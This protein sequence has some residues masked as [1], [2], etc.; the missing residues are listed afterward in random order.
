MR[1]GYRP[2]IRFGDLYTDGVFTLL[3]HQQVYPG[4]KCEMRV[5]FANPINVRAY[6]RAGACFDITEGP[7]KI[8]E[9]VILVCIYCLASAA[10]LSAI[11]T[12]WRHISSSGS[13]S[14]RALPSGYLD[15]R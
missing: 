4:D 14:G 10:T 7:Q 13:K 15:G 1:C 5:T 12:H 2:N 6:L 8:G 9:G 11:C 3:D